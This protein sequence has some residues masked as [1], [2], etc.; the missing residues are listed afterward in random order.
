MFAR[1]DSLDPSCKVSA[2]VDVLVSSV[3]SSG[4]P[5][6][7]PEL[8]PLPLCE[9]DLRSYHMLCEAAEPDGGSEDENCDRNEPS[10]DMLNP[11]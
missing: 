6:I 10:L 9:V 11:P 7:S 5:D 2:L 3:L 1:G 4:L 8:S